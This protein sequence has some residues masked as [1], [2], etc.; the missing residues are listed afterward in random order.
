MPR[1][2]GQKG[3]LWWEARAG[4]AWGVQGLPAGSHLPGD[5]LWEEVAEIDLRDYEQKHGYS[6]K[7]DVQ[8]I[9]GKDPLFGI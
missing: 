9:A 8:I 1:L 6:E 5:G 2:D 3:R 4:T 7:T